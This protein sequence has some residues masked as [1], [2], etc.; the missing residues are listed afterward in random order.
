VIVAHSLADFAA[1]RAELDPAG[2]FENDWLRR[3]LGAA[4][5]NAQP[6]PR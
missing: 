1:A 5:R 6:S 4:Q 3:V 2:R